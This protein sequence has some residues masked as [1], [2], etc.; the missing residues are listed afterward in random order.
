MDD[1]DSK[2]LTI[3]EVAGYLQM[4]PAALATLRYTGK[5]PRFLKLTGR[6]VRYRASDLKAW[7]DS[8]TKSATGR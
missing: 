6:L 2:L 1:D 5:G 3:D 7:L 8:T 4:T